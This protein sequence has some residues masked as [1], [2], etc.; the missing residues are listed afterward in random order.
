MT[1]RFL[2]ALLLLSAACLAQ[3]QFTPAN[4]PIKITAISPTLEK[5]PEFNIG[6]GPQRKAASQDWLW[7][8]VAYTYTWKLNTPPPSEITVDYY[9][10]LDNKSRATPQGTLLT[11]SV[12]H[13]GVVPG[14]EVHHSVALVSPQTLR[15]MFGGRAPAT[16][17][18]AT[19]A[20]GVQVKIQGALAGELSTGDGKGHSQWWQQLPQGP[21]GLV[22]SKDQTPFAPLFYDYFDAVKAKGAQ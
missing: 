2:P 1:R 21:G 19:R 8:E 4:S 16:I 3:A 9:I 11:G 13:T 20:I 10:L 17:S 15:S 6:I 18:A 22:L 7:V 12:T 14:N 5:T